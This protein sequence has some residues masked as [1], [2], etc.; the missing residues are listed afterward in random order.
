MSG[1]TAYGEGDE[2]G[3]LPSPFDS[4]NPRDSQ[5]NSKRLCGCS[6]ASHNVSALRL[7]TVR[8]DGDNGSLDNV[9]SYGS[10]ENG[11]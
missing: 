4:C 6:L 10:F 7:E 9:G 1:S 3:S 8:L 11:G 5:S 2:S